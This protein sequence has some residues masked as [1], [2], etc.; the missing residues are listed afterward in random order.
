MNRVLRIVATACITAGLVV[1]A[2]VGLTLAWEEP[3]SNLYATYKQ[4]QAEDELA[5][6]E[7][8]FPGPDDLDAA[9][10]A[11]DLSERV[12]IL[13]DRFAASDEV[14]TG[15]AIGRIEIPAINLDI[16]VVEGTD[17]A[18]LQKGPGHYTRSDDADTRRLGDGSAFPGQGKTV[19]IAGHR[20]TYK[21]P[22]RKTNELEAGDEIIL[23]MPYATF[24]YE[25]EK[26]DIVEPTEIS[27]VK[28][29]GYERLVLSACHPLYSAAQRIITFAKLKEI[30]LFGSGARIWQDP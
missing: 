9:E 3:L 1:A 24:T 21:A 20:T 23:E 14:E 4:G 16:V 15:G 18:S 30:N 6:L 26:V 12:A 29:V 22:F 28:N 10:S 13:A 8:S 7:R 2:D 5:E 27:V 17:T 25:V 11:G 19:G